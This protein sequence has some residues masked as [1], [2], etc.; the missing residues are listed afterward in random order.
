MRSL[1]ETIRSQLD[2]LTAQTSEYLMSEIA[3]GN[4]YTGA[5][6]V[7]MSR[8]M[9]ELTAACLLDGDA[10]AFVEFT[11]KSV[12]QMRELKMTPSL[13]GA[14]LRA[15]SRT[16]LALD[17][18][19]EA[20]KFLWDMFMQATRSLEDVIIV[21]SQ[22]T[23]ALEA[24]TERTQKV[25]HSVLS[26]MPDAVFLTD[27]QGKVSQANK[28][29]EVLFGYSHA[30][31]VGMDP[32]NL[33]H[34]EDRTTLLRAVQSTPETG[35]DQTSL[36]ELRFVKKDG[37][38]FFGEAA[39]GVM[40]DTGGIPNGF[41]VAVRD[42]SERKEMEERVRS[43]A[44]R[45][46]LQV[47][48]T[49]ELAQE[50]VTAET[51]EAMLERVVKKVKESFGYYHVQI[52]VFDAAVNAVVLLAGYGEAGKQMRA[53]EYRVPLTQY[54]VGSAVTSGETILI[55]NV[56][57]LKSWEPE[58][59]LPNTASE[60]AVPIKLR[61]EVVGVLDV[62][63]DQPWGLNED[64]Q[65]LLEGLCGQIAIAF[66]SLRL[67]E[68]EKLRAA[69]LST[70]ARIST[71][72][73]T[74]LNPIE[75]LQAVV[76]QTRE[77]FSLYH[78]QVYLLQDD[79]TLLLRA[80]TGEVGRKL[81]AEA[82][83]I[84]VQA[85]QSLVARACRERRGVIV[86]DV[87]KDPTFLPNPLLPKTRSELAVPLLAG[88]EVLGVLDLQ[89][90]ILDNF[91]EEDTNLFISLASQVAVAL[92]NT[93]QFERLMDMYRASQRVNTA[94]DF[95]EMV[96]VV[97]EGLRIP[98]I[99]RAELI[100]FNYDRAGQIE[101]VTVQGTWYSGEGPKPQALGTTYPNTMF[102]SIRTL[103]SPDALFVNDVFED[104]RVDA[105]T[106]E[107][108][109]GQRVRAI[110]ILPLWILS[111]QVGTILVESDA[112]HP[113]SESEQ[114]GYQTFVAQVA[115]ALENRRLLIEAQQRA[116]EL[117]KSQQ[118]LIES[119]EHFR[120]LF[121]SSPVSLWEEDFSQVKVYLD[122]LRASGVSDLR[123]H[124]AEHPEIVDDCMARIRVIEV[125]ERTLRL[126]AARSKQELLAN[127][128]GI[129]RDETK[130]LFTDELLT[131][132][133]GQTHFAGE[134]VNY[135]LDGRRL[136]VLLQWSVVPGH[137]A[138]YDRLLVSLEDITSRKRFEQFVAQR[139]E[140]MVR[141]AKVSTAISTIL[142]RDEMLQTVVDMVCENFGLYHA[143][144]YLLNEAGDTL[145]LSSGSGKV[146]RKLVSKGHVI[147][148][149]AARSLVARA[150]RQ[151]SPVVINDVRKE[152]G[153]L[154]NPLLPDTRSE[155][156]IPLIVGSRILGILDVQS[157]MI[158]GFTEEDVGIYTTLAA[159][160][161]VSLQNTEQFAHL[162]RM[163]SAGQRINT[164]KTL[165][166]L[167]AVVAEELRIS[168]INR[169]V[170]LLFR[171][172]AAGQVES[173]TVQGIWHS[174]EGTRPIPLG[175]TYSKDALKTIELFLSPNP[176]FSD[177][178]AQD[179]NIDEKTLK[180]LR[181]LNMRS[182]GVLPVWVGEAHLGAIVLAGEEPHYFT[183]REIQ[184][185]RTL[186]A[187]VA[188]A[189][190]NRRLLLESGRRALELQQSQQFLQTLVDNLPVAVVAKDPDG[191]FTIWNKTAEQIFGFASDQVLG[192]TDYDL[193]PKA[194]A[195][196]FRA[197]DQE[198]FRSGKVIDIPVEEANTAHLGRRF[199]HTVNV[200]I[201]DDQRKPVSLVLITEDIT[202]RRLYEER[203]K[204]SE[205][206]F[207]QMLE[208]IRLIATMIDKEGNLTFC[209]NYLLE[210][211]GWT[212][213]EV[214]GK[215]WFE[216]FTPDE[217]W[218]Q[219]SLITEG[220]ERDNVPL[221]QE[222]YIVTRYGERRLIA[223]SNSVLR[224]TEGRPIGITSIGE[225]VTEE[226]QAAQ[227][228][229]QR[230][231]Q[232]AT[233]AEIST[234]VST[235][236]EPQV[237]LQRVV[238]LTKER[239]GLYHAHI[240]LLDDKTDELVLAAGAGEVGRQ[241]TAERRT[242]SLR[243]EKSLVARAARRRQSDIVND[244][245]ADPEFLPNPLLPDTRA[246][247]A[248]PI[249]LGDQVL[250]VLDVQ[251]N[252]PNAFS[253][254][255]ADILT[256]LAAQIAVA[257]QNARQYER[258][259]R[260]AER[261]ALINAITERIQ[262]A[263]SIEEAMQVAVREVGRALGKTPATVRLTGS[264]RNP[265]EN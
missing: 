249:L 54:P 238:D 10:S 118:A 66:E 217:D 62:H 259:R 235:L 111:R 96:A 23:A 236:L 122:H 247:L 137:E 77:H 7:N 239:F 110:G 108:L 228:I 93:R 103:L 15:L 261:E 237:M 203:I 73:S 18:S 187:Q 183:D 150:C 167:V 190:E 158:N 121:A 233:V 188:I 246:E 56:Q 211:T 82:H 244:V 260:S 164:A 46:G 6:I 216:I 87:W 198:A 210:L 156:A 60:I 41:I 176:V 191:R 85:E 243:A 2:K 262:N 192:K 225:D 20:S 105:A 206:R 36:L 117:Q 151:R 242:I 133:Q 161:A 144:V 172:N 184:G 4:R 67:L 181:M 142:D 231:T 78:A 80:S 196:F 74:I 241:M 193:F 55:P 199:L 218:V 185:L 33:I 251:A 186:T 171:H 58:A 232:L 98:S 21:Q 42:I 57:L 38:V 100:I 146:G 37:G 159:Q 221:Y 69:D 1:A 204:E 19:A 227:V 39:V 160:V 129:F 65:N 230:A 31:L 165:D 264:L 91:S 219:R 250:G 116:T 143:H 223:W 13:M 226:R 136:D 11:S 256:T 104:D 209:N 178:A 26:T 44:E 3:K 139:A 75:M 53:M 106:R 207:R 86:N 205:R 135:T 222:N 175:T 177:D 254:E 119:E 115:L 255:D 173:A 157:N 32:G 148:L 47:Q 113:F 224:D 114:Q 84:P 72:V 120:N 27:M 51:L 45:R 24:Q 234:T 29:V 127:L 189:L 101:S 71:A 154:P 17:M 89:S 182:L 248:T 195:D 131:M 229:A 162:N 97:A 265:Q 99:N 263:T 213:E 252:R 168:E 197:N 14:S 30:E 134:G 70:V 8:Q 94:S 79:N 145:V 107:F 245:T 153:F 240:Y 163:Y 214:L 220:I 61:G 138:T 59:L 52:F 90:N 95:N 257:L 174:G 81:I 180:M 194:Q 102:D 123:A 28:A 12:S 5:T 147:P 92:Q 34:S 253:S 202:E 88:D 212:R 140:Q 63:S 258:A 16:L 40:L 109:R 149:A 125:N 208:D 83:A 22:Q 64:D 179:E 128:K 50:L 9:L 25:L 132:W 124:I 76:D 49:T 126:F 130:A 155:A 166:E 170:L 68:K 35:K 43:M 141:V 152:P 200:P 201:Y 215:N 112:I 48:V 169:G